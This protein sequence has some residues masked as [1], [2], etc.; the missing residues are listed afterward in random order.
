MK[1]GRHLAPIAIDVAICGA[2]L[3]GCFGG[4][5]DGEG[6]PKFQA[7]GVTGRR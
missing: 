6:I 1:G 7:V 3:N 5:D 4:G 2:L